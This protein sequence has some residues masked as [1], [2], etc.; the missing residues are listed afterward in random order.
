[1]TKQAERG[2]YAKTAMRKQQ[3]VDRALDVFHELGSDRTSLR[4]I[5]DALGVTHPVLR[6]HFGSREQLFIEVLRQADAR[7]R[8]QLATELSES[9]AGFA[10][11]MAE[12]SLHEPGM[13]ALFNAMIA[14]ALERDNVHSHEYFVERYRELRAEVTALLVIGIDAGVV[15]DDLPLETTAALILAASDG[16]SSQWL[17]DQ[18]VDMPA[19]MRLLGELLLPR[20][21]GEIAPT[22]HP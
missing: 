18:S 2:P 19:G 14:R 5:A 4:S 22:S 1:M 20:N 17:L 8:T 13:M 9:P 12:V 6:H 10:A 7:A 15:R 21:S 3:I 11:A 16:L